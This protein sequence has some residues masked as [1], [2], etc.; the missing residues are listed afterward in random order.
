M[1]RARSDAVGAALHAYRLACRYHDHIIGKWLPRDAELRKLDEM[2]RTRCAWEN[3]LY[4]AEK[5][6]D[7]AGRVLLAVARGDAA[8]DVFRDPWVEEH[9]FSKCKNRRFLRVLRAVDALMKTDH[10]AVH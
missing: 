4:R 3:D 2:H 10:A 7:L 9:V 6:V 8:Q 5:L 1:A